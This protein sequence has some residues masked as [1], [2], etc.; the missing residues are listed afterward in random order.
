[1]ANM[2]GTLHNQ[3]HA[4]ISGYCCINNIKLVMC[5]LKLFP[6]CDATSGQCGCSRTKK[7]EETLEIETSILKL[8]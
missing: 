5:S 3:F 1:M 7:T 4:C 6:A 8:G 2:Y